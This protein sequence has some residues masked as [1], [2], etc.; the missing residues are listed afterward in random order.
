MKCCQL[1]LTLCVAFYR[2]DNDSRAGI[3]SAKGFSADDME[4]VDRVDTN[5]ISHCDRYRVIAK[6]LRLLAPKMK[7]AEAADDL[8]LLAFGYER[9]ADHLEAAPHPPAGTS[10]DPPG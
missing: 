6:E 10:D 7:L 8:R 9:L 1:L 3:L 4:R 2:G 5:T